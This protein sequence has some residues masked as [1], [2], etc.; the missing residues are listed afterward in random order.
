MPIEQFVV[1]E[2]EARSPT[3]RFGGIGGDGP[4]LAR[5]RRLSGSSL[6]SSRDGFGLGK[7]SKPD[8]SVRVILFY[9]ILHCFFASTQSLFNDLLFLRGFHCQF[10][11]L[12]VHNALCGAVGFAVVANVEEE[13]DRAQLRVSQI[14]RYC[15]PLAVCHSMKLYAQNKALEYLTPAFLSMVYGIN[16]VLVAVACVAVGWER[17]RWNTLALVVAATCGIALTAA[18]ESYTSHVGSA[19]ALLSI[20]MEVGRLLLLQHLLKHLGVTVGGLLVYTAPLEIALLSMGAAVFEFPRIVVELRSFDGAFWGLL[21]LNTAWALGTNISTYYFVRVS[22]AL[23]TAC[24]APFKD[25]ATIVLS[26]LL[27]EPR[28][29]SRTAVFGYSLACV[30]SFAYAVNKLGERDDEDPAERLRLGGRGLAES[31]GKGTE[32]GAERAPLLSPGPGPGAST[33][34]GHEHERRRAAA[35]RATL[36]AGAVTVAVGVNLYFALVESPDEAL[37]AAAKAP[38]SVAAERVV[39]D[40]VQGG[41]SDVGGFAAEAIAD[42][43]ASEGEEASGEE[44]SGEASGARVGEGEGAVAGSG[45]GSGSGAAGGDY[46]A[47]E[48]IGVVRAPSWEA[49]EVMEVVEAPGDVIAT[50]AEDASLADEEDGFLGTLAA[51]ENAFA[52]AAE[53][54]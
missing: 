13:R 2:V 41:G 47:V 50:V 28:H 11:L 29:E 48:I 32:P 5:G 53:R 30:A 42:D 51:I 44:A 35:K 52:R 54:L 16:P 7:A 3:F 4:F 14:L 43:A 26:D 20:V 18:G 1:S 33:E 17:F 8:P 12:A 19:L 40:A 21:A 31:L 49:F 24:A 15:L 6:G 39:M 36:I 25:V 46:D 22:S 23:L 34:R 27:V 10:T 45:S 37:A 9:F 38:A